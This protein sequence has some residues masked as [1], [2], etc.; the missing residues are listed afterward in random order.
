[1]RELARSFF[2]VS[3]K[4]DPALKVAPASDV[5]PNLLLDDFGNLV[6]GMARLLAGLSA[7]PLFKDADIGLAEWV[8]L[9]TLSQSDAVS[10]NHLAKKLG[11]TRQRAHQIVAGFIKADLVSVRTAADDSRKN[12]ITLTPAGKARLD[13]VNVEIEALLGATLG[14]RTHILP[15]MKRYVSLLT[16][17]TKNASE[18][19]APSNGVASQ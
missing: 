13:A 5:A 17:M 18:P 14:A 4:S 9:S 11:V 15:K 16:R 12:E 1:M 10:N 8:A 7:I 6:A 3:A 2:S 19:Q